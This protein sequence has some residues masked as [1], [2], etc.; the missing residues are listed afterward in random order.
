LILRLKSNATQS[1]IDEIMATL[2][3][4]GLRPQRSPF[5]NPHSLNLLNVQQE[6]SPQD[7]LSMHPGIENVELA[8]EP[9]RLVSRQFH[10]P[11][12]VIEINGIRIGTSEIIMMAGPCSVES[13]VL[14][15]E[16]ASI[17]ATH[18]A[19]ILR[20]GAFKPRTSPYSFQGLG[21]EGLKFLSEAASQNNLLSVTEVM[22]PSQVDFVAQFADILQIGARNMQNYSL[23]REVG[24]SQLPVLLKRGLSATISEFLM[25]AEY[26]LAEGNPTVILCERGIRTFV[27]ETR[28]TLDLGSIPVLREKSHLPIIVDPSHCMGVRD[29]VI[30]MARAGIAAGADG[31]IVEIHPHPENALSD[32]PQALLP[33]QF[34][35]L[36][37][38][39]ESLAG[40]VGRE[41]TADT[42]EAVA[43][44]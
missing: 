19:K 8:Q 4:S 38:Q 7:V 30:P 3:K 12:H 1:E 35:E 23:L 15:H 29:K 17:V 31:L 14:I 40:A 6:M 34:A 18:G 37:L 11:N 27:K 28:F 26:I 44:T 24:K 10:P 16:T 39:I 25:A 2:T 21:K 36:S 32:G 41:F 13:E 33:E 5:S 22:E 42:S 43:Q 9:F 20:G